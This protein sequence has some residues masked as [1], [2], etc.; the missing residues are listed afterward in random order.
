MDLL[1]SC[2][3]ATELMEQ[4]TLD[5]LSLGG[6]VQLWMH[7][8]ICEACRLALAQQRTIE[9]LLEQRDGRTPLPDSRV[10]EDRVLNALPPEGN[11]TT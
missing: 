4:R 2:R 7:L 9:R 10:L 1:I 11:G 6:R 3:K 8:R 5:P